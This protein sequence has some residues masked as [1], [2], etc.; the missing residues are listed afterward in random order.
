[1]PSR[2]DGS[3]NCTDVNQFS[4]YGFDVLD[5]LTGIT[6]KNAAGP[7]IGTETYDVYDEVSNLLQKTVDGVVSSYVYDDA[8]QL[9]SEVNGGVGIS[10]VYD[11]NGNR[12]TRTRGSAVDL[13]DYDDGDKLIT[14]NS[15]SLTYD[16]AGRR[17]SKGS[18]TYSWNEDDRLVTVGTGS[19]M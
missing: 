10:Y 4:T 18:T 14:L 7:V 11:A 2:H 9:S 1:V 3:L 16:T 17:I 19:T 13:Y 5:R 15:V 6:H 12:R 8:D